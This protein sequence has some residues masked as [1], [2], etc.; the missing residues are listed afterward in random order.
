M[1][2]ELY[3]QRT[4]LFSCMKAGDE[5]LKQV[6]LIKTYCNFT[7]SINETSLNHLE[8]TV[9]HRK[10]DIFSAHPLDSDKSLPQCSIFQKVGEAMDD[11]FSML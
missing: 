10:T 3:M 6:L 1:D 5:S 9:S 11:I 7:I 4:V 8:V 2:K